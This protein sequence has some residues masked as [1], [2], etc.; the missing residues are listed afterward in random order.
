MSK[1]LLN[2]EELEYLSAALGV[3]VENAMLIP[4]KERAS[5]NEL[6]KKG[7]LS[8]V[9]EEQQDEF[10]LRR[11]E[12]SRQKKIKESQTR[13]TGLINGEIKPPSSLIAYLVQRIRQARQAHEQVTQQIQQLNEQLSVAQRRQAT[14]EGEHNSRVADLQHWDNAVG[15]EDDVKKELILNPLGDPELASP[16]I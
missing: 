16:S 4:L 6:A 12:E 10:L 2:Q 7:P 5:M 11:A 14:L 9:T 15:A 13:T 1:V 8:R 3:K